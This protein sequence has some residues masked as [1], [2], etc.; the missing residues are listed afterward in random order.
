[1]FVAIAALGAAST[2]ALTERLLGRGEHPNA[3]LLGLV[4]F[5]LLVA[6]GPTGAA[7]VASIVLIAAAGP[8]L[9]P[10]VRRPAVLVLGRVAIAAVIVVEGIVLIG[11]VAAVL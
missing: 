1:M 4:P 11:D 9:S 2:A 3:W 6:I 8:A 5:L 10:L 7:V